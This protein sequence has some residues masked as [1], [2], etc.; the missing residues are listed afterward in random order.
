[1]SGERFIKLTPVSGPIS[2][3]M[4]VPVSRV[5][6]VETNATP[7]CTVWLLDP[8]SYIDQSPIEVMQSLDEVLAL[9]NG[10]QAPVRAPLT[11]VTAGWET[12]QAERSL[13]GEYA[14]SLGLAHDT[15][16]DGPGHD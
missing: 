10:E 8:G 6:Q 2:G 11:V 15:S 7:G 5:V 1:M 3:R 4:V 12:P 13:T 9:L 14:V 16:G